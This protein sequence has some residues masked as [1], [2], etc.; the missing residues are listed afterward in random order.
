MDRL[1][2]LL[3]QIA[4]SKLV[5]SR[6]PAIGHWALFRHASFPRMDRQVEKQDGEKILAASDRGVFSR[7]SGDAI[8]KLTAEGAV[9]TFSRANRRSARLGIWFVFFANRYSGLQSS[10]RFSI[11]GDGRGMGDEAA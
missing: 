7:R 6:S 2:T 3:R 11:L 4:Q 5:N 10:R 8:P 1:F 9:S